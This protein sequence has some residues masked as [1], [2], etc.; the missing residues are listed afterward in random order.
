MSSNT[1]MVSGRKCWFDHHVCLHIALSTLFRRIILTYIKD[2]V[3]TQHVHRAILFFSKRLEVLRIMSHKWTITRE[4]NRQKNFFK[5]CL[6]RILRYPYSAQF[7]NKYL[8]LV[9]IVEKRYACVRA[10]VY[11]CVYVYIIFLFLANDSQL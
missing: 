2:E 1:E 3:V 5:F 11:V 10:C 7:R 6:L 9:Y 4:K 8:K